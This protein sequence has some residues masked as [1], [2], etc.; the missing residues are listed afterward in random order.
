[1]HGYLSQDG[2]SPAEFLASGRAELT[3]Y[4]GT[5]I[6]GTVTGLAALHPD[7]RAYLADGS[8]MTARRVL[9]ATG[10]RDVLPDIPGV[11]ERWG[12]D[13]LHCPYCHGWEV[14]DQPIGVLG[15][16]TEAVQHALLLRQWSSNIVLFPGLATPDADQV[17][18]LAARD[19]QVV[20]G[21]VRSLVVEDDRLTG[22]RLEDG[23]VIG[24]TAVFVRPQFEPNAD[25]LV[26]LGCEMD[27]AGWVIHDPMGRTSVD[28]AWV[29][30]N[31]RNAR[32]QVITAAGEGS[33]AAIALHADLVDED[34]TEALA[35]H[36][37]S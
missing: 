32:A 23:I 24:R 11:Q 1:M 22:V 17:E 31:T 5:V 15:G 21:A 20:L 3:R 26:D 37:T 28:G 18:A 13:L 12:K 19:V 30:G 14:R 8:V 33:A 4:G 10:L 34:I 6:N 2:V 7:F 16:D 27:T 36:R 29:A 35:R 9:V 25:L